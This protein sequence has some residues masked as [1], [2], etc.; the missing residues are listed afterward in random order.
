MTSVTQ[1]TVKSI[2]NNAFVNCTSLTSVTIPNSVT[3]I[4]LYAFQAC[5]GLKDVIV[6]WTT[7]PL[8]IRTV[9]ANTS[10]SKMALHVP[11]GTR[12]LYKSAGLWKGF[13]TISEDCTSDLP[14]DVSPESLGFTAMGK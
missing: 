13:G 5:T 6:G 14:T 4:Q 10:V 12:E 7:K 9:F 1:Y 11:C 3:S 2:R 8:S